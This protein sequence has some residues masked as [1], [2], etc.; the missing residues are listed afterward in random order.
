MMAKGEMGEDTKKKLRTVARL[1]DG[2]LKRVMPREC[3][4][5]Y[6]TSGKK[7]MMRER[8]V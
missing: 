7:H 5:D 8:A 6:L 2:A 4:S 1:C 3:K